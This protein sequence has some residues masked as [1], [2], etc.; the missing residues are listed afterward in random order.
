MPDSIVIAIIIIVALVASAIWNQRD[1][2]SS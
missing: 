2:G 1:H